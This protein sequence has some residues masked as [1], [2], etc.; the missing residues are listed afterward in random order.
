MS[1]SRRPHTSTGNGSWAPAACLSMPSSHS[2]DFRSSS[3]F[4]SNDLLEI[5]GQGY[6]P[7]AETSTHI[8]FQRFGPV[9]TSNASPEYYGNSAHSTT[10]LSFTSNGI[11]FFHGQPHEDP[12]LPS[13]DTY[14]STIDFSNHHNMRSA[15]FRNC[16]SCHFVAPR[17]T[18]R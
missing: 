9:K 7:R 18:V 13:L 2:H 1:R 6:L 3:G 16:S 14:H 11:P 8:D 17:L 15:S 10:R 5:T 4:V 12:Q